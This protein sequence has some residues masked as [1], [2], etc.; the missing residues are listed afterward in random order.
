MSNKNIKITI[1]AIIVLVIGIIS[2]I[3]LNNNKSN[4]YLNNLNLDS[5]LVLTDDLIEKINIL[6]S[7]ADEY[8]LYA[9]QEEKFLSIASYFTKQD[10]TLV[11][12]EDIENL[13][14]IDI[15]EELNNV[16]F[17]YIKPADVLELLPGSILE[18][19][20][21]II[22]V[23]TAVPLENG[24]YLSSKYDEGGILTSEQYRQLVLNHYFEHGDIINPTK[25]DKEYSELVELVEA[26]DPELIGGNVKYI[27]YD[28]KYAALVISTNTN[29]S[30][31]KEFA[32]EK[33][34]GAWEIIISN[35]ESKQDSKLTVN[36]SFTDFNLALLP[37]YEI[38]SFEIISDL[39]PYLDL[40]LENGFLIDEE[41][42]YSSGAGKFSYF[43]SSEGTK[44]LAYLQDG[45]NLVIYEIDNYKEG[46]SLMAQLEENP[47]V[48]IL[49]F[50]N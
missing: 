25:N 20:L 26:E 16:S 4:N 21:E 23:F 12:V 3:S 5:D 2:Y 28:D 24:V 6:N 19:D 49:H 38:S 30:Y 42:V 34:N 47:P 18:E 33:N 31:S 8:Y 22:T 50:E 11:T 37:I 41:I 45:S 13:L 40:I 15:A 29:P 1:I 10:N 36:Y 35:L 43:E 27:A 39:T 32:F 17:H 44:I 7:A 48:F 46:I 14:Y 9:W